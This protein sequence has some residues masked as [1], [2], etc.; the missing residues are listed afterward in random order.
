VLYGEWNE[1]RNEVAMSFQGVEATICYLTTDEGGGVAS[2]YRGQFHYQ[3][4]D[5]A[6]D[7]IQEFPDV[8]AGSMI[9]LGTT[10]RVVLLFPLDRWKEEH[11]KRIIVG[12]PFEIREGRK[13]VGRGI[14]TRLDVDV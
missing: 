9:E 7:A 8:K 14:V 11:S 13:T 2:G 5:S 4:E 1:Y 12:M 3:G 6:S 10:V